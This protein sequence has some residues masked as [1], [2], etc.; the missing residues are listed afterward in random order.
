[1]SGAAQESLR[2]Q[3]HAALDAARISQAEACRELG[4]STK[5][6]NQMLSGKAPITLEWAE[7]IAGLC[8]RRVVILVLTGEDHDHDG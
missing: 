2:V 1:M 6:L 7:R 8:G 4:V 3:I 5:H